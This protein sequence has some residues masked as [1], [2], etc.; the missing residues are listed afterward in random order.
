VRVLSLPLLIMC[1]ACGQHSDDTSVR[2]KMVGESVD[3]QKGRYQ[4]IAASGAF[5]PMM[6]DTATGCV[7]TVT[8]TEKGAIRFGDTTLGGKEGASLD[9]CNQHL[10]L[11]TD[12]VGKVK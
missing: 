8:M 12:V 7:R 11:R 2:R 5:P 1:S 4:L 3:L 9:D 6:I 10:F